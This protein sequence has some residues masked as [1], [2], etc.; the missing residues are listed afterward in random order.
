MIEG[1]SYSFQSIQN[2]Y[3]IIDIPNQI[4]DAPPESEP[5]KIANDEKIK[6]LSI[7]FQNVSFKYPGTSKYVIRNMSFKIKSGQLCV[8]VG[9]NGA[10]KSTSLK[11]VLRLYEVDEGTILI[12][13]RDIRTIPLKSL[14]QCAA[15]L[16]QDFSNFPLSIREN[17][18]MGSPA[19]AHDDER[20]QEAARLG[21]ASEFVK[22]L[23]E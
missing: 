10:A 8:I 23:P 7:E 18:A 17:I 12:D 21:G 20:I 11:L 1:V 19:H 15:V 22:T 3:S 14:R 13:G 4:P 6:G 9:E 2:L 16:F 5:L